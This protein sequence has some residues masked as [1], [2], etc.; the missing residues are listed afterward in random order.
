MNLYEKLL[1][2]KKSV[3]GLGKDKENPHFKFEYVSSTKTLRALRDKMNELGILLIPNVTQAKAEIIG[4]KVF[5]KIW[6]EFTWTNIENPDENIMIRWY[7]QGIDSGE[8]GVGKAYTYAE[9]YFLLKFFNIPTDKDDP[10]AA[11]EGLEQEK[12]AAKSKARKELKPAEKLLKWVKAKKLDIPEFSEFLVYNELIKN[13]DNWDGISKE[14]VD[15]IITHPDRTRKKLEEF[16]TLK[17]KE[18]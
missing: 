5:T 12:P 10:D 16:R 7:A 15:Y 14:V 4:S 18:E 8:K 17:K 9:K 11:A 1:E 2:L 3:T 6:M 13:T